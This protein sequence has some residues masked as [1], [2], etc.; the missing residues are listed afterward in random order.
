MAKRTMK[1]PIKKLMEG[2]NELC[3]AVSCTLGPEGRNV[4]MYRE[5]NPPHSTK[6]GVTVARE[7]VFKDEVKHVGADMIKQASIE[8]ATQAGDGTTTTLVLAQAILQSAVKLMDEGVSPIEIKRQLEYFRDDLIDSIKPDLIVKESNFL[9]IINKV[10][11]ISSNNDHKVSALITEAY[12]KLGQHAIMKAE[13]SKTGETELEAVNGMKFEN[14]WKHFKFVTNEREMTV[15][16]EKPLILISDYD[17]NDTKLLESILIKCKEQSR[18]FLIISNEIS[19]L[20]IKML[21][22]AKEQWGI[23]TCAVKSPALH[24]RRTETLRDIAALTGGTFISKE[25]GR[26]LIDA[27]I[28]DL[29]TA[30]KVIIEKLAT[31]IIDG[32]GKPDKIQERIDVI[33]NQLK[34]VATTDDAHYKQKLLERKAALSGG[35]GII[36]V[37]AR[38]EVAT[39][40]LSDRVDDAIRATRAALE[41]GVCYGGGCVFDNIATHLESKK[42]GESFEV[43]R[44]ILIKA[45]REPKRKI[46]ESIGEEP[47]K[48]TAYKTYLKANGVLDPV[49][50]LRHALY[51]AIE[52]SKLLLITEYVIYNDN[53]PAGE[54]DKI[55][56][57]DIDLDQKEDDGAI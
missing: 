55:P 5:L 54:Y 41:E 11:T 42:G 53:T 24:I 28:T 26:P 21:V 57:V 31:V 38:S 56:T 25:F 7:I 52:V 14:G 49:K 50:V 45:L 27:E 20:C 36:K 37:G 23:N 40:E 29:G 51:N 34:Q 2:V 13:A 3:D 17:I 9:Q 48:G 4:L 8:T 10:A 22:A 18:N 19:A 33:N 16:L 44:A 6:D 43:G 30:N 46:W 1:A 39:T 35:F 15:E 32:A 12:E 47:K